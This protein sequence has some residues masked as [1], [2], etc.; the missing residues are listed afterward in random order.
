MSLTHSHPYVY[1]VEVVI[2]NFNVVARD[3]ERRDDYPYTYFIQV[4]KPQLDSQVYYF[5]S[6]VAAI[7]ADRHIINRT[8]LD[9]VFYNSPFVDMVIKSNF[10][11]I[12]AIIHKAHVELGDR[13]SNSRDFEDTQSQIPRGNLQGQFAE[14]DMELQVAIDILHKL[15]TLVLQ[16]NVYLN[17][18][19]RN[20]AEAND[21]RMLGGVATFH[22]QP[23]IY[24]Q[25]VFQDR[26][27]WPLHED[28]GHGYGPQLFSPQPIPQRTAA[29]S[30][31]LEKRPVNPNAPTQIMKRRANRK[32]SLS[33][34]RQR[35][36]SKA[37]SNVPIAKKE[38][39]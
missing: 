20:L 1:L 9:Y 7:G 38:Q 34:K 4:L 31:L 10:G 3:L 25:P 17:L 21:K 28:Q 5:Q 19:E 2:K 22:P 29:D 11:T 14:F 37:P 32:T 26:D 30:L 18:L 36:A 6:V 33:Q 39:N 12:A 23:E 15:A 24:P 35:T 27:T 8:K 13:P 16:S